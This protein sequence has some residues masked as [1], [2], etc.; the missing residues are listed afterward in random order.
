MISGLESL[1]RGMTAMRSTQNTSPPW[2]RTPTLLAWL[3]SNSFHS[4][5]GERERERERNNEREQEWTIGYPWLPLITTN[6]IPR[7]HTN[8]IEKWASASAKKNWKLN[9]SFHKC[10]SVFDTYQWKIVSFQYTPTLFQGLLGSPDVHN[11][12]LLVG[13]CVHIKGKLINSSSCYPTMAGNTDW[14]DDNTTTFLQWLQVSTAVP[15]SSS[16]QNAQCTTN[17][18]LK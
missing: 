10:S 13:S 5:S 11:Q 3:I 15:Q 12:A 17:S 2:G 8:N 16:G 1:V 9:S 6:W 4:P 18:V 7:S 14:C